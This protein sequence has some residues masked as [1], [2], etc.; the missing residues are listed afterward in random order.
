MNM[1]PKPGTLVPE[2]V[3]TGPLPGSRKVYHRAAPGVAVPFREIELDPV[4]QGAAGAGLRRV[5]SLHRSRH[6]R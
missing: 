1:Q 2:S 5:G 3:T 6:P 4:R